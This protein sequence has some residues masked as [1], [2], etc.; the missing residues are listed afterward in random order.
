M[1]NGGMV[2]TR[3]RGGGVGRWRQGAEGR[4]AQGGGHYPLRARQRLSPGASVWNGRW[5]WREVEGSRA[6]EGRGQRGGNGRERRAGEEKRTRQQQERARARGRVLTRGVSEW[7]APFTG[8][9]K[10]MGA[11]SEEGGRGCMALDGATL[12]HAHALDDG[13]GALAFYLWVTLPSTAP[14]PCL[15]LR[16]FA[17]ALALAGLSSLARPSRF[18]SLDCFC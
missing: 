16:C 10:E 17:C 14:S 5:R 7:S 18:G 11:S 15:A 2:L 3:E 13:A 6:M 4:V 8:G 9:P 1:E 12:I